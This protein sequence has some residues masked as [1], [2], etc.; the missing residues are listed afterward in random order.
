MVPTSECFDINAAIVFLDLRF[1]AR[2]CM[3]GF[4]NVACDYDVH[5][6]ASI[7]YLFPVFG[8][9]DL[10]FSSNIN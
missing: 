10:A 7:L 3:I 2:V 5:T 1:D 6:S 4:R 9:N 8:A